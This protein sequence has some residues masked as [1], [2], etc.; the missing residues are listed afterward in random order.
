M[1]DRIDHE[2]NRLREHYDSV[3]VPDTIDVAIRNGMRRAKSRRRVSPKWTGTV[4]A[5]VLVLLFLTLVRV[6]PVFAAYVSNIP[7]MEKIVELVR[8]DKGL[9]S[10]IENEFVQPIGV[11]DEHDGIKI[12]LD[13]AIVDEEQMVVFYTIE[14][15]DSDGN[16]DLYV[17]DLLN[18]QGKEMQVSMSYARPVRDQEKENGRWTNEMRFYFNDEPVPEKMTLRAHVKKGAN[19]KSAETL[20]S[21]WEFPITIDHSKFEGKKE[22]YELN[23]TLNIENQKIVFDKMEV[24]PTRIG[25]HIA[26]P[27]ENTYKIF[28]FED[29]E[30]VDETGETWGTIINGITASHPDEHRRIIYFQSNYFKK[31][32]SLYLQFS[33]IRALPKDQLDVVVD[34]EEEKILKAPEDGRMKKVVMTGMGLTFFVDMDESFQSLTLN[35]F[36]HQFQDAEGR[37]HD[38]RSFYGSTRSDDGLQE[39][40]IMLANE[41]YASPL[42]FRLND[43]P[44]LLGEPAKIKVK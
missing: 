1:N 20:P 22:T 23:R 44:H 14:T 10:A 40:G 41:S 19:Y 28:G 16:L 12:T 37:T 4:A 8:F 42:T 31:P 3:E 43:Y 27:E 2:L 7:G 38:T 26:F 21:T 6:S 15:D 24:F 33:A 25:V 18:E 36:E 39:S 35:M 32:E 30:L 9:V 17:I 13:S 29:L 5:A 11:S 34:L